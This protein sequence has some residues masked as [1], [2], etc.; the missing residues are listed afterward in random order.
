MKEEIQNCEVKNNNEALE[1]YLFAIFRY[2][3]AHALWIVFAVGKQVHHPTDYLRSLRWFLHL[4][5]IFL[6][7]KM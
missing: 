3:S 5:L 4:F 1:I 7:N 2:D 6:A